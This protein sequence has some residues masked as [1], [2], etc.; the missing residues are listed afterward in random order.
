MALH[1]ILGEPVLRTNGGAVGQRAAAAT[2]P[3]Q[4]RVLCD[5]LLP[6]HSR[7]AIRF[8]VTFNTGNGVESI[9]LDLVQA[10][11]RCGKTEQLE[12]RLAEAKMDAGNARQAIAIELLLQLAVAPTSSK[13]AK[14]FGEF[15]SATDQ[16]DINVEQ[17]DWPR[18]LVLSQTAGA[19]PQFDTFVTDLLAPY[20][21]HRGDF[22]DHP[23]KD[24][25]FDY[26]RSLDGRRLHQ[27]DYGGKPNE[28]GK[29]PQLKNWVTTS[30][31][32]AASRGKG[33]PKAHWQV[34][35]QGVTKLSGHE[36]DYLI[37]QL[38]LTGDYVVEFDASASSVSVMLAGVAM[39]ISQQTIKYGGVGNSDSKE[40]S[41]DP[42]LS[43]FKEWNHF[44]AV[45]SDGTLNA[46]V[47]GRHVLTAALPQQNDSWF[48]V[49]SWRRWRGTLRNF[50]VS[51][52]PVVPRKVCLNDNMAVSNWLD[53]YGR[54]THWGQDIEADTNTISAPKQP[55]LAGAFVENLIRYLRPMTEDGTIRYDFYYRQGE[56][57]VHPALDRLCFILTPTGIGLHTL[58]DGIADRTVAEPANVIFERSS[59]ST[60]LPLI[61]DAWNQMQ[62]KVRGDELQLSLNGTDVFRLDIPK[63]NERTFGM[64]HYSDQTAV[65]VRN[66]FWEGGWPDNVPAYESQQI[67]DL[68]VDAI[69]RRSAELMAKFDHD[70]SNGVPSELFDFVGVEDD[71][72]Q[73]ESG[74]RLHRGVDEKQF[75]ISANMQLK[76]DF[77]V[78]A[79][80]S[81]LDTNRVSSGHAG[82]GLWIEYA[83]ESLDDTGIYRRKQKDGGE[84]VQHAHKWVAQDGKKKF[85]G[86]H[87]PEEST[88]GKL[89]LSRRGQEVYYMYAEADSEY[90]RLIH[91][92]PIT[93][94]DTKANRVSLV[95]QAV[96][97]NESTVT[98]ESLSIRAEA[99]GNHWDLKSAADIVRRIDEQR[100][101]LTP[102]VIDYATEALSSPEEASVVPSSNRTLGKS[103]LRVVTTDDKEFPD[104]SGPVEDCLDFEVAVDVAQI[105]AP[106]SP[107]EHNEVAIL[108]WMESEYLDYASIMLRRKNLG[109]IEV[110]AQTR[111]TN[112]AGRS[113]Y[114]ALR[115]LP[116]TQLKRMRLAILDQSLYYLYSESDDG[117][118]KLLAEHP[119]QGKVTPRTF[120]LRSE[121]NGPGS[122]VDVTW[123]T[124]R[125]NT[126]VK[127][128]SQSMDKTP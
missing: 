33:A 11:I 65:K 125:L 13:A 54:Q 67:R 45:V 6:N 29:L 35:D 117:P 71:I 110:F 119:L 5:W 96:G 78:I 62:L 24:A 106:T 82:I 52:D 89:R 15:M 128:N 69:N 91:K 2:A 88:A 124:V 97:E 16:A 7:A 17:P 61:D 70:F 12:L 74:V 32:S 103:G 20:Y 86:K 87:I 102:V 100:A 72:Q 108:L 8:P 118:Y 95:M 115:G 46:H 111:E 50:H 49:R 93:E 109:G 120:Y 94:A 39:E 107:G 80:F 23:S 4:F 38:P 28:F 10:A 27:A 14:S 121:S 85:R 127:D 18:L 43:A 73:T 63:D 101:G 36:T 30:E 76:G 44:R 21:K 31:H 90:F 123:K 126:A 19:H 58:T 66:V 57:L 116:V 42:P 114:W 105:D 99:F 92:T 48:A 104:I 98:W 51:G 47:N 1:Q 77:D 122:T 3:K 22:F 75:E 113:H 83:D 34:T 59:N 40:L 79:R 112:F 9:V 56:V 37:Y 25:F 60:A 26:M 68:T 64:F 53:Y 55:E 84:R 81:G 41:F